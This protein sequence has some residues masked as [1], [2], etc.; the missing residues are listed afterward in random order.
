MRI[1]NQ[2]IDYELLDISSGEKLERWGDIILIRPDPQI[3]WQTQKKD[4]RWSRYHGRYIR[5]HTGGGEWKF[6]RPIPESWNIEYNSLKFIIRPTG[7]K[8]T[9]VFPEQ[10]TNWDYIYNKIKKSNKKIKVLNLFAY[11]GGATLAALS[12]GA[13]VCHVDSSKGM[14]NWAKENVKLSGFGFSNTRWIVDDCVKFIKREA[15]RENKYDV[16]IL[17]P[18]SYG[19][20]SNGQVWKLEGSLQEFLKDCFKVLSDN[21]LFIMI[22]SYSKGLSVGVINYLTQLTLQHS[23]LL[24]M[25]TKEDKMINIIADEIGLKVKSTGINF[26]CGNTSI[27]EFVN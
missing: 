1:S 17:D 27:I 4:S 23:N 14:V 5:H 12:A 9:G 24:S 10:A 16:I 20:G 3:I 22:N 25:Q 2:W 13:D 18:P 7:F 6:I 19:K 11:T 26:P 21:P 8:H 15:R